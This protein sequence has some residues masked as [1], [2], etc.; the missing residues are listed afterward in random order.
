MYTDKYVCIYGFVLCVKPLINL[1]A[2]LAYVNGSRS[3][4]IIVCIGNTYLHDNRRARRPTVR[5]RAR[6]CALIYI[7]CIYIYISYVY[8]YIG[9]L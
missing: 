3:W 2:G 7:I 4:E 6:A 1:G 5:A 8:I 9:S